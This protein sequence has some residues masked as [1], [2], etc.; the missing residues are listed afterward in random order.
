LNTFITFIT[1]IT[2]ITPETVDLGQCRATTCS[3]VVAREVSRVKYLCLIYVDEKYFYGLPT[4]EA[5]ALWAEAETV[6]LELQQRPDFITADALEPTSMATTL[7]VRDG[8]VLVTDGPFAEKKEHLAGFILID[9][10]N[11]DE[12][13]RVAARV[14]AVRFGCV[15][16]RPARYLEG[17][18]G[19]QSTQRDL[20]PPGG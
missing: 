10:A 4:Q 16:V 6:A 1:F 2:S 12:A 20:I 3:G 15:E 18:S 19:P 9:A 17:S 8:A 5:D 14:P 11:L 13:I 7:R